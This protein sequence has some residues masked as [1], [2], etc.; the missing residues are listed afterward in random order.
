[1][2]STTVTL[3]SGACW[4]AGPRCREGATQALMRYESIESL[5][6]RHRVSGR[7]RESTGRG[8]RVVGIRGAIARSRFVEIRSGDTSVEAIS[9]LEIE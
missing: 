4:S 3:T 8:L 2:Q 9:D 6:H 7:Y 1:M 5:P